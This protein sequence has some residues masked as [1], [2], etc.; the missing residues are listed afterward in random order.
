MAAGDRHRLRPSD[1]AVSPRSADIR[2]GRLAGEMPPPH[3]VVAAQC[4]LGLRRL[5]RPR[6]GG[7]GHPFLYLTQD[8]AGRL[9][10]SPSIYE[11]PSM[12]TQSAT[13]D[14]LGLDA[15]PP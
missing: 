5:R 15:I 3:R 14:Q 10:T 2:P 7:V 1:V 13:P 11:E 6:R 4:S 8:Q 9:R 12:T